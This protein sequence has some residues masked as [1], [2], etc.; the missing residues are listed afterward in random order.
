M[1]GPLLVLVG[2]PGAGKSTVGRAVAARLGVAFRDTDD[3]VERSNIRETPSDRP[4]RADP[5]RRQRPFGP[6]RAV[7]PRLQSTTEAYRCLVALPVFKTGEAEQL[8][9][10]GSIPV[11]LRQYCPARARLRPRGPIFLLIRE[12]KSVFALSSSRSHRGAA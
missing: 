5:S 1:S 2:A 8:G 12:R 10:A 6:D 7:D 11:R 4:T 9:L 3:D